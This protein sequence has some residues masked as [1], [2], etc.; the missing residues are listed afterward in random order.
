M[1]LK[2][3]DMKKI[4]HFGL[5]IIFIH[6]L[7][8]CS[9]MN[10]KHDM[11]LQDGEI[12]YIGR[13]D[14]ARIIPGNERFMLRYWI[15][16]PRAKELKVYW[17]EKR[18]SALFA[19]PAHLATD[20]MEVII[21]ENGKVIPEGSYTFQ[22]I[23]TNGGDLKSVTYEKYGNVFGPQFLSTLAE[24][25]VKETSYDS[26]N[27]RLTITWGDPFS[28]KDVG[29]EISYYLGEE[30]IVAKL[31]GNEPG[32][33]IT[34]DDLNLEKGVSYRTMFLP[35][36]MAID[37]FFTNAIPIPVIQNIA[38]NK[39][40]STSSNLNDG[41]SGAKAV[42]GI[43]STDSRWISSSEAGR[44]HWLVINLEK[45]SS[46]FSVKVYKHLYNSFYLANFNLQA[47]INGEWVNIAVVENHLG[48]VYEIILPEVV[49]TDKIRLF[50]PNYV[51]N[52]VRLMELEV[53]VKY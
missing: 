29:V 24:R 53:Y 7:A 41:F 6:V 38:K 31:S 19:I 4:R 26:E 39:P 8:S 32:I 27:N 13:V 21:G 14:S 42:D 48:A 12:L 15:T 11:Y 28:N 34:L 40:V 22:L 47:E 5:I 52:M 37:T 44:E 1:L 36:K 17:N 30:K 33:K 10:E 2:A 23:S 16:D 25:S 51:N 46:L 49:K 45:E 35:E 50:V 18:D 43:I 3:I 20:S 9:E